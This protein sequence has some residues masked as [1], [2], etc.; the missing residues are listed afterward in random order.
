MAEKHVLV[1]GAGGPFGFEIVRNLRALNHSVMATYR[2]SRAVAVKR[3]HDVGAQTSQLDLADETALKALLG[4][5]DAAIFTPILT[6]SKIASALIAD[7]FPAVFF[8]SNNAA[9]D[10]EAD[11]YARLRAAEEEVHKYAPQAVILRPTMIYGYPGDGNLAHLMR[12]MRRSPIAPM[13]GDGKAL[14]QPVYYKDLAKI[15]CNIAVG[16]SPPANLCAVAG[17]TAVPQKELYKAVSMAAAV[18]PLIAPTPARTLSAMLRIGEGLGLRAPLSSAQLARAN[19]DKT[20]RGASV[21]L[22]E[23]PLAEGLGALARDLDVGAAGA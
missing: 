23:T 4:N 16:A 20:P 18:R 9:I 2:T 6:V 12:T 22:G 8:S 1:V 7:R 14:Q 5:A 19:Q 3:L 17:P 10:F 13:P 21:I 11:V 15:A